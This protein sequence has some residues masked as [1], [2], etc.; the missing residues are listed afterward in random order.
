VVSLPEELG[1]EIEEHLLPAVEPIL[2]SDAR[3][4]VLDFSAVEF[5]N[6]AGIGA[7]VDLLRRARERSLA[8]ALAG[9]TGQPEIILRR[10]G[11]FTFAT[12]YPSVDAALGG[13]PA[14]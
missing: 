13:H 10:V 5:A 8:V 12:E 6:S 1:A 2:A 9:V 3:L 11:F 4:L 7:L 14:P